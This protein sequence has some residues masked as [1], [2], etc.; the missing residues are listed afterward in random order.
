MTNEQE[1]QRDAFAM[2]TFIEVAMLT[3]IF[4]GWLE[5]QI[6]KEPSAA[7]AFMEFKETTLLHME[8]HLTNGILKHGKE[9]IIGQIAPNVRNSTQ[10]FLD[11]MAVAIAAPL[12]GSLRESGTGH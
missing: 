10:S 8:N 6:R 9:S 12:P 11:R 4:E 7:L 5:R 1:A 2:E 3:M